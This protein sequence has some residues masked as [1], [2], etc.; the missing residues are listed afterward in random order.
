MI[1]LVKQASL[2]ACSLKVVDFY[3]DTKQDR[4]KERVCQYDDPCSHFC[5]LQTKI[6]F[7]LFIGKQVKLTNLQNFLLISKTL[8][9]R[10]GSLIKWS[11]PSSSINLFRYGCYALTGQ[12]SGQEEPVSGH[13]DYGTVSLVVN[14]CFICQMSSCQY[15]GG[16]LDR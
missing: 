10:N 14:D 3:K 16:G 9:V 11:M 15:I 6:F 7:Y 12:I 13:K 5:M 2:I 8:V 4:D 1:V